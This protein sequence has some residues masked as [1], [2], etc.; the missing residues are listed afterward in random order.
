MCYRAL[1]VAGRISGVARVCHLG[2]P[3]EPGELER[4]FL[5]GPEA[6][7]GCYRQQAL[8]HAALIQRLS[9]SCRVVGIPNGINVTRFSDEPTSGLQRDQWRFGARHVV[10]IVGHISRVKGYAVFVE[11]AARVVAQV[12]DVAFVAVGTD[13]TETGYR[14]LIEAEAE[15]LGIASRLH[16]LGFQQDVAQILR[17]VDVVTLPSFEEGLPLALLEAMACGLPVVT[18]P[19]GGIPEAVAHEETGLL[20]PTGSSAALATA[21]VDLLRNQARSAQLGTA[22]RNRIRTEFSVAQFAGRVQDLYDK[23]LSTR[24]ASDLEGRRLATY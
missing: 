15:R 12:P 17:S 4:A 8:D 13:S 5:S 14:R 16:F 6:V 2:F 10:A 22:A 1:G 7:I 18:T 23:L 19:V 20:V 24:P 21:I 11:A 9:P 3:P